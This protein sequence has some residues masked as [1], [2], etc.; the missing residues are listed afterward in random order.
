VHGGDQIRR[1]V[2][3]AQFRAVS[4]DRLDRA[5]DRH[6]LLVFGQI[7]STGITEEKIG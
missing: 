6:G 2:E 4:V 3:P 5:S 7:L 1:V